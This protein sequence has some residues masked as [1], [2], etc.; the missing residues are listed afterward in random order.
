[1]T[2]APS[3]VVLALDAGGSTTRALVLDPAGH[4]LAR[5]GSG[6][7][8]PSAVGVEAALGA[9]RDAVV[10][11]LAGAGVTGGDVRSTV[12]ATAGSDRL[13][14]RDRLVDHL[15]LDPG[16]PF[17]RVSD[18]LAMFHSA[19]PDDGDHDTGAALVAGTGSVAARV[20]DGALERVVGGNGWLLGDA[21]AGFWMGREVARAVTS[22]LDG[23]GPA[24]ALTPALLAEFGLVDDRRPRE[25]RA[26]VL[27]EIVDLVYGT[28]PVRLARLAPACFTAADA[29]DPV[30]EAVVTAAQEEL[31]ALV[32]AVDG[33]GPLVV[34]GGVWR[35]GAEGSPAPGLRAAL[36]GRT[37][38]PAEDGLLGAAALALRAIGLPT[39]ALEA[40]RRSAG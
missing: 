11:A 7:G 2:P 17:R 19:I 25:G 20:R 23:T 37:V 28:D 30:A 34:G 33:P 3:G 4:P 14:P 21:G 40:L 24:T 5:A 27:G 15:G 32:R 6:P 1:M 36:A 18:L 10:Q 26:F 8:N 9:L 29:G 38:L 12:L 13:V 16:A 39:D 31:A 22:D 35:R